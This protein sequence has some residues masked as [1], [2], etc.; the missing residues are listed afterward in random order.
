MVLCGWSEYTG[1]LILRNDDGTELR[2]R[3]ILDWILDLT[4]RLKAEGNPH[5]LVGF[6]LGYDVAMILKDLPERPAQRLFRPG[7]VGWI[8]EKGEP[9]W[10]VAGP[11]MFRQIGMEFTV[12]EATKGPGARA[13]AETRRSFSLW[14]IWKFFQGSFVNALEKW[15]ILPP[16]ELAAM[17]DMKR[18]R[19]TFAADSI[20]DEII[21]YCLSECRAGV[22]L[23]VKLRQTC[24]DLGYPLEA[25]HG[26]GSLASAMLKRWGIA[27][28]LAP[29]PDKMSRAVACAYVG[30]RFEICYIGRYHGPVWQNDINSAY[31]YIIQNLPCLAHGEWKASTDVKPEGIY[32]VE[33]KYS[34]PC[35][36]GG[37]PYRN[38]QGAI[39]FPLS[40]S[41][42]YWGTE[43]LA[44]ERLYPSSF[45]IRRG[46]YF[47]RQCDHRPFQF[48]PTVYRDRQRL[49]ASA[50]GIVLKLGLN[51]LYG[52]TA[53]SVGHP[54]YANYIWAG[55]VTAG[56]R[57]MILDAIRLA[58]PENVIGVATDAIVTTVPVPLPS[59]PAKVLGEWDA[60]YSASGILT[61]QPGITINY[62]A[63]GTGKY[64]SR[65]LGKAEF[66]NHA[67]AA[68]KAWE[69]MG[70]LGAFRANSHRFM[71][72]KSALARGKYDSRCRWNEISNALRYYPGKKRYVTDDQLLAHLKHNPVISVA[73]K[74]S[75]E[76]SSPYKQILARLTEGYGDALLTH[77]Q[78]A[79]ECELLDIAALW[80]DF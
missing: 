8:N 77:E 5:D 39:T 13:T 78:P 22:A 15:Q 79:P 69:A 25:Y 75:D 29:V 62:D 19:S 46:W 45:H 65:G 66:A 10:A 51:S 35:Y 38:R 59:S 42:W 20:D 28:Y 50:A 54:K 64:K 47:D 48:I 72:F 57:A 58:G 53:Q 16:D 41:G 36:W 70:I 49:G 21:A 4:A 40:G 55:M 44:A 73:P 52:K 74:G 61:I 27:D 6:G 33:W 14:D 71:G 2:T 24:M 63:N 60:S 7:H 9:R 18:R 32:Q 12:C 3:Q 31:P 23:M 56:C 76:P 37:L 26:A 34:D 68:E 80:D 67:S 1:P 11:Y 17:A 30:G 43:L